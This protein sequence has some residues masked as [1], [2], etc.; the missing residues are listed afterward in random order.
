MT[1]SMN[2][3]IASP[4]I[5]A[6]GISRAAA[7]KIFSVINHKPT[8]NLSKGNGVKPNSFKGNVQFRNVAFHYPSRADVPV[9]S[10]LLHLNYC[11]IKNSFDLS[12]YS[13]LIIFCRFCK[14]SI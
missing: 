9:S 5:E 13:L 1:G 14:G 11:F 3:G 10:N 7:T 12:Y 8:I 2:F 6:F 4:Y